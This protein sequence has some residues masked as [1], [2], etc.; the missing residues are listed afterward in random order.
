MKH[1][2]LRTRLF[3]IISLLI[4][5][6]TAAVSLVTGTYYGKQLRRQTVNQ[7]QQLIDQI[8]I[9]TGN[10]VSELSRLCMSPY[11][12]EKV[13]KLLETSPA[14]NADRLEKQ[15]TIESFLREMM[16]IPRKDILSVS[17][18]TDQVYSVSRVG[19]EASYLKNY[20]D[21]AWYTET[22]DSSAPLFI[23]AY[24]E[25]YG[26]ASYTIFSM[27]LRLQSLS[28]S[29]NTLGLIR[30]DANYS[31]IADVMNA[32]ILPEHGL[33]YLLEKDGQVIY[34][35]SDMSSPPD[36]SRLANFEELFTGTDHIAVDDQQ[37]ILNISRVNEANWSV[38]ALNPEAII[39]Q[40]VYSAHRVA[41]TA[42][43]LC[44]LVGLIVTLT[45]VNSFLHPIHEMV[46]VM[47][48]A[49]AGNYAVRAP[50]SRAN[51]ISYLSSSFNS[52]L[53]EITD[54]MDRNVQLSREMYEAKYLRKKAQ[55]D[56]LYHQI[57]PH[58]LFNTLSTISLLI[59]S[60]EEKEAIESVDE[61]S[62]LLRSMVNSDKD[63]P[64]SSELEIV[65]SYLSLQARRHDD[66]KFEITADP[67]ILNA[68]LPSLTIQPIVENALI[69]GC[70][71]QASEMIISVHAEKSDD[72]I[73]ITVTDNG[74]GMGEEQLLSITESISGNISDP[75]PATSRSI[76]LQNIAQRIRLR[77]GDFY[78]LSISS[79][80]SRGTTVTVK[81]PY[82]VNLQEDP[83]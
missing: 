25:A 23:H 24:E 62:T 67:Q 64:L 63:I 51:E 76:G 31:G 28:D 75:Q 30:V 11:Y 7:T 71:P 44:I 20:A 81:I 66:L 4:L 69:H 52:M 41:V 56:A 36:L 2:S 38:I 49:Q 33:L 29:R 53:Q 21:S 55:Y 70:E 83:S 57:R 18:I 37:Y 80:K 1:Y 47:Q 17:I 58:F 32:V 13:M 6:V 9:N 39:L 8:S 78:G 72:T 5:L 60:G 35:R 43:L 61:L 73:F 19:H 22:M 54:A 68:C 10:Y 46:K 77:F 34:S 16:T 3:L 79:E 15:R 40:S 48:S 42:A 45:F 50:D 74:I 65:E 14:S 26:S 82:S 59:K 12:H 27:V